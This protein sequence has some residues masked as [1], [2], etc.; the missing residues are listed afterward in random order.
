MLEK[1]S[2]LF[3]F[4]GDERPLICLQ[5]GERP[6]AFGT[7][8]MHGGDVI[9]SECG[10]DTPRPA[11]WATVGSPAGGPWADDMARTGCR[12]TPNPAG[13]SRSL[14]LAPLCLPVL[15]CR[16]CHSNRDVSVTGG[17]GQG[18]GW[19]VGSQATFTATQGSSVSRSC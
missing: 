3:S 13:L 4:D 1:G 14:M 11:P 7:S 5:G 18:Q 17:V 16:H 9:C 2:W 10:W 19:E 8:N 6:P 15:W 12:P